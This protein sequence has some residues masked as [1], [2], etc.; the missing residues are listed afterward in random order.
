MTTQ[1]KSIVVRLPVET[2]CYSSPDLRLTRPPSFSPT[3]SY[4]SEL[5]LGGAVGE[6]GGDN[7]ATNAATQ[8]EEDDA[9]H[10]QIEDVLDNGILEG[11][12]VEAPCASHNSDSEAAPFSLEQLLEISPTGDAADFARGLHARKGKL[13]FSS[14]PATT[15]TDPKTSR[16]FAS[17]A[18]GLNSKSTQEGLAHAQPE[19]N[20]KKMVH[21][22]GSF[23]HS[24][25]IAM[26]HYPMYTTKRSLGNQSIADQQTPCVQW[27]F[28][29]L[30]GLTD[31]LLFDFCPVR[32]D[33]SDGVVRRVLNDVS[34]A[35]LE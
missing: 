26:M 1:T 16:R 6:T 17:E 2:V 29:F 33:G 5:P 9:W 12:V 18:K 21:I 31:T 4:Q 11:E 28:R 3:S 22:H 15:Y 13:T 20:A 24:C 32:L 25:I 19:L 30:S 7:A 27:L 14:S 34:L 35:F 10:D 23:E 8:Q